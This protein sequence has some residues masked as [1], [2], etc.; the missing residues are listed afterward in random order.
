LV[1]AAGLKVD[2]VERFDVFL[3]PIEETLSYL[4]HDSSRAAQLLP[5]EFGPDVIV[6]AYREA[7]SLARLSWNPYLY[8]PKLEQRL[9]RITAPTLVIWG[10]NDRFL[11]I[12]YAHSYVNR[13]PGARLCTIPNCGHFVPF[14]QTDQFVDEVTAFLRELE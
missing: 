11:P 9:R 14:E 7:A 3:H 10:E 13:I 2:G 4:F 12:Q 5:T 1:G 8:D 6:R